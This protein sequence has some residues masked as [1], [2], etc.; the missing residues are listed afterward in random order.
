MSKKLTSKF[1]KLEQLYQDNK[2]DVLLQQVGAVYW[3]K[4]KSMAR[5]T[6]LEEFCSLAAIDFS[7]IKGA[8]KLLEHIYV[9]QPSE[10]LIDKFIAD[11]YKTERAIR[12]ETETQLI[13]ELYKL[14]A[15]D[16]GGIYQNNLE[17][18]IVDNYVKKIQ[19]F[20]L[21]SKKIE[22]EIHASTRSYVMS[23]WYNHWTSIL[24]EDIF[25][26]HAK[27][28]PTVGLVKKVDFFVAGIPY[29]LK[30]TYFP[31]GFMNMRRKELGLQSEIQ[32][33]KAHAKQHGIKYDRTLKDK[34]IFSE[35]L[36]RIKESV[37]KHNRKS[38][39]QL[40]ATRK[41]IIKETISNPV[42]LIRWL[43]ENQGTRRFDAANRLFVVL[44]DIQ[45]LEDSWKLKRNFDLL[46]N[47]IN[48]YLTRPSGKNRFDQRIE[49][50]WQ[51]S[52][53]YA[54]RSD[55]LFITK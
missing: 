36:T 45:N 22:T 38:W 41:K 55:I 15:F 53:K 16:W 49:F 8:N 44:V 23:S 21:L 29:D 19:N 37:S 17:R 52:Q 20:T 24:I 14:Q 40:L 12:K 25:K 5:K 34:A 30:V 27:V 48:S 9:Q 46:V 10:Q 54:V 51:G 18:T 13:S 32:V 7:T 26:D 11:K 31:D 2:F 47:N 3:L 43:Y 50:E 4:M 35:L 39:K 6:L 33:L 28:T 1:R 42:P